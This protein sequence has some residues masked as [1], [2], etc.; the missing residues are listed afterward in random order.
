MNPR[1]AL[2]LVG[3]LA[4]PSLP[5][6]TPDPSPP[7][8]PARAE[9][10]D[11]RT[12]LE[13][14]IGRP[15]RM[16]LAPGAR[17]TGRVYRLKGYG[18]VIVLA[19]LALPARRF[20]VHG[21]RP[22]APPARPPAGAPG[23]RVVITVPEGTF[24][25]GIDLGDLEREMEVQMAAQAAALRDMESAQ[26]EWTRARVEE[27]RQHLRLVEDQAEAFRLEAERARRKAE[28]EVR[29]RLTPPPAPV[30]PPLPAVPEAPLVD[31]EVPPPPEPPDAPPPWRFWFDV[32]DE[33]DAPDGPDGVD[34]PDA[35]ALVASVRE[36]L[37]SGLDAYRRP[38]ASLRPDEFVTVAVDLVPNLFLRARPTRTLLVRVRAGDLQEHRAGRLSGPELRKRVEFEEN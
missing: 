19:P 1:S 29:T 28:R 33:P 17:A 7:A 37:V 14:A 6:Q 38:L 24:D 23:S 34:T 27:M 3:L 25:V 21:N 9:L 22:G 31:L 2:A 8:S 32:T 30:A 11:L 36:R 13:T 20:V 26:R 4:G 18:A 16:G 5:A 12:A 10:E 15:S 35:D